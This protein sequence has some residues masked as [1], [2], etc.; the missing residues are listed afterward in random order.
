ML[1]YSLETRRSCRGPCREYTSFLEH[2]H[3]PRSPQ[4]V[5]STGRFVSGPLNRWRVRVGDSGWTCEPLLEKSNRTTGI[6]NLIVKTAP[7]L[8]RV[9]VQ[10]FLADPS[11]WGLDSGRVMLMC[12]TTYGN[13]SNSSE[14]GVQRFHTYSLYILDPPVSWSILAVLIPNIDPCEAEWLCRVGPALLRYLVIT[15]K[16]RIFL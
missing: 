16:S 4:L 13:Q 9:R 6:T 3:Y 12:S 1:R 5:S 10:K 11:N 7:C 14:I 15:V 8:I 2:L